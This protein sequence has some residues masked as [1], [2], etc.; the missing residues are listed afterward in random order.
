MHLK[1]VFSL[2]LL[3][4]FVMTKNG[5]ADI[6]TCDEPSCLKTCQ[7]AYGPNLIKAYCQPTPIGDFCICEHNPLIHKGS[8][9]SLLML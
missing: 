7:D 6:A 4:I 5:Q 2:I 3:M 1:M 9:K 8:R